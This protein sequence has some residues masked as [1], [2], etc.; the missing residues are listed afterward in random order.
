MQ[1]R[2]LGNSGLKISEISFGSWKYSETVQPDQEWLKIYTTAFENGINFFDT[3]NNYEAGNAET[4]IGKFAENIG[5]K[6]I[7]IGTKCFYP[8]SSNPNDR[9]LSRKHIF[10]SVEQ[11]LKRLKTDYIDLMQ[12]H[13]WDAETPVEETIQAMN[14]LVKQGKILYWGIGAATA[15]QQV[16]ISLKSQLTKA[17]LPVSHQHVYNMFNRTAEGDVLN[18]GNK[19]GISLLAYSPLAQG[20]LSGKYTDTSLKQARAFSEEHK[21]GMWD[22][23][24]EKIQKAEALKTLA[25][26]L[27]VP[28]SALALRWCMRNAVVTSVISFA[29]TREQLNDNL[30]MTALQLSEETLEKIEEILQNKPYNLYTKLPLS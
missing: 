15:A 6:N 14:D 29:R 17:A 12:C 9:G 16:E 21:K 26:E 10:D 25:N 13:R 7:V 20:V 22:F 23:S 18:Y 2:K 27:N 28:L 19:L 5:R 1:Y 24:E 11:S 3:S 4:F 8:I 30:K